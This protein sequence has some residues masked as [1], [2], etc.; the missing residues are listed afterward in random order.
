MP[1]PGYIDWFVVIGR[2]NQIQD[3]TKGISV[4]VIDN[5]AV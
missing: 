3:I 2:V 4:M 5:I 1:K